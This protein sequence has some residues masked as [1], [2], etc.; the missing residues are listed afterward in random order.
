MIAVPFNTTR[1]LVISWS[2]T[3][4]YLALCHPLNPSPRPTMPCAMCLLPFAIP[5]SPRIAS[6]TSCALPPTQPYRSLTLPACKKFN[7]CPGR[8]S[9]F[10]TYD[11]A[12]TLCSRTLAAR[13]HPCIPVTAGP[14]KP[15]SGQ[16]L[17]SRSHDDLKTG[18]TQPSFRRPRQSSD[19]QP[20]TVEAA[21]LESAQATSFGKG[22]MV[23][24]RS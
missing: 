4:R 8:C 2:S 24:Q 12:S 15:K 17:Y 20:A 22:K 14:G 7:S 13:I 21:L 19:L 11:R 6:C 23:E 3:V 1:Q 5:P 18:G 10:S 16:S 9:G